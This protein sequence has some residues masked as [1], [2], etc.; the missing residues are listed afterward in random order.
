MAVCC[1][2][3]SAQQG[4]SRLRAFAESRH[5]NLQSALQD[6]ARSLFQAAQPG[7]AAASAS[8]VDPQC[9]KDFNR[10]TFQIG[11]DIYGP[12]EARDDLEQAR[13]RF[14][15][16]LCE[17]CSPCSAAA[18]RVIS[19]LCSQLSMAHLSAVSFSGPHS[20][21]LPGGC[22]KARIHVERKQKDVV[23]R[24]ERS[25]SGFESFSLPED[26]EVRPCHKS[27]FIHESAEI[28]LLC[29]EE[30]VNVHLLDVREAMTLCFPDTRV[31]VHDGL[32]LNFSSPP[33]GLKLSAGDLWSGFLRRLLSISQMKSKSA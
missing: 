7:Q 2:R 18:L 9:L 4:P 20:Y 3:N 8:A 11:A 30:G 21:A 5:R 33:A 12:G 6:E 26:G 25:A 22:T 19:A 23:L 10:C 29:V 1:R 16:R 14:A 27:S 15:E 28:R 13:E 32:P 31:V 17:E 24:I